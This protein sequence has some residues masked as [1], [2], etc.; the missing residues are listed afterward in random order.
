[1]SMNETMNETIDETMNE[2]IDETMDETMD[3]TDIHKGLNK[4]PLTVDSRALWCNYFLTHC[5][6]L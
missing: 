6:S 1:M 4:N 2:T 3:E 5:P